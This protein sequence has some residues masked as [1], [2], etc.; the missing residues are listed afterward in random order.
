M[1]LRVRRV[2]GESLSAMIAVSEMLSLK[3]TGQG[4]DQSFGDGAELMSGFALMRS[5]MRATFRLR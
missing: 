3:Y 4:Y 2:T 5:L 1:N